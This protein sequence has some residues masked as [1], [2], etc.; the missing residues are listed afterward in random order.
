MEREN[1]VRMVCNQPVVCSIQI[2]S[3]FKNKHLSQ[4]PR[5]SLKTLCRNFAGVLVDALKLILKLVL[6]YAI[7]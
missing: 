4:P 1:S 2:A 3:F 7:P 5:A 6:E